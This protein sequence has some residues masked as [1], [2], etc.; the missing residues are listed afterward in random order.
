MPPWVR[1]GRGRGH[2]RYPLLPLLGWA[3]R[4][5]RTLHWQ[6]LPLSFAVPPGVPAVWALAAAVPLPTPRRTRKRRS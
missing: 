4:E 2:I 5:R 3:Q 6:R 1:V